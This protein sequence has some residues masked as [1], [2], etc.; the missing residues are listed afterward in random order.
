MRRSL[1]VALTV[2]LTALVAGLTAVLVPGTAA[3]HSSLE[4]SSPAVGAELAEAPTSI[5]LVFNEGIRDFAPQIAITVGSQAP[6]SVTPTVDVDTVVADLTGVDIPRDPASVLWK[7]GY[8]VVSEDGHPVAGVLEFSVLDGDVP[9]ASGSVGAAPSEPLTTADVPDAPTLEP[10]TTD[11]APT[12]EEPVM[13]IMTTPQDA[14]TPEPTPAAN[15]ETENG[16]STGSMVAWFVGGGIL[17]LAIV[18]VAVV[19]ARRRPTAAGRSGRSGGADGGGADG[20]TD[21]R[22]SDSSGSD[23]GSSDSGGGSDGG[24]GG[25]GD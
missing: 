15:A 16:H 1:S 18:A 14:T 13:S 21:H 6:V 5:V 17:I 3:A 25:G 22:S 2:L 7:V 11:A 24:G 8:R 20:G 12:S 4:N 23:S 9:A 10:E 19:A